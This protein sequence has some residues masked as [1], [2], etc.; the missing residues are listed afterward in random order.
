VIEPGI[1]AP[2]EMPYTFQVTVSRKGKVPANAQVQV[3]VFSAQ[4]PTITLSVSC[5][6]DSL[7]QIPCCRSAGGSILAAMESRIISLAS[8]NTPNVSFKWSL[9]PKAV[10]DSIS[11]PLGYLSDLFVLQ[12]SSDVFVQ[13][14]KYLLQLE[15]VYGEFKNFASKSVIINS[16]PVGGIFTA[17]LLTATRNNGCVESGLSII[18]VFRLSCTL[19]ADPEGSVLLSYRFGYYFQDN[20][21]VIQSN[22]TDL[23]WFDWTLDNMKDLSLPSGEMVMM[24]QIQD[25]CGG[26]TDIL[27][28][29][30]TVLDGDFFVGQRRRLLA[31]GNF[32]DLAKAKV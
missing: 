11:A 22:Q 19:W 5:F 7:S 29:K 13:G 31:T 15:G 8:S 25:D 4:I 28:S 12:G 24:A 16:P 10:F 6:R 14:S 18:D 1:L 30:L 21:K 9:S 26:Q 27:Y 23:V 32:W 20:S 2:L 3:Y 17:C